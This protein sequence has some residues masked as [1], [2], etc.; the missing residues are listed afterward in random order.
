VSAEAGEPNAVRKGR[1]HCRPRRARYDDLST[2]SDVAHA[3]DGVDGEPD[4]SALGERR[5]A[6]VPTSAGGGI[7][8]R[9]LQRCGGA[10]SG[11]SES[12][13]DRQPE[14]REE[15]VANE[16]IDPVDEATRDAED[17]DG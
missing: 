1:R 4:V 3:R 13:F 11:A 15:L 16:P 14:H 17:L 7:D 10:W 12:P 6:R 8:G 9:G 5:V 2:V